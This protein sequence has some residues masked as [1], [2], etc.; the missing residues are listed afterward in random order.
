MIK[1]AIIPLAGLGTRLLPLT[2]VFAKELLP[3][4][5]K[6][7]L[8]YILEECIEAGIKEVVFIISTKKKMIK[9]YFYNDKFF[10]PPGVFIPRPETELLV[11]CAV[12]FVSTKTDTIKIVDFCTGSGCI[13][14]SIAKKFP[15]HDYV[16]ID[17]SKTAIKTANKNKKLLGCKNVEFF[18]H[19]IF[20]Y[21]QPKVDLILCNPPYLANHEIQNLEQSI[22][23]N[24]PMSALTD[25]KNGI[26]FYK[27]LIS[28]FNNLIKTNGIMLLE[29]P[30][31]SV[32]KDIISINENFNSNKSVLY[33][34]LEGKNRVVKIY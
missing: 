20:M 21:N 30:F 34:D 1:Q 6:T 2:S 32:T 14:L 9:N 18:N 15:N 28:N 10:T 24:E 31:S 25:F 23:Q 16:G 33:K 8:E 3:I 22:K 4:N 7:N 27:Y 26:S 5:G 19:D 17:K 29:I 11:D 13:L 12:E